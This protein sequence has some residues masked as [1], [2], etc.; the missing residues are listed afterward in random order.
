MN[1]TAAKAMSSEQR[2]TVTV[3]EMKRKSL[4]YL[5][6]DA[7]K[8]SIIKYLSKLAIYNILGWTREIFFV[9]KRKF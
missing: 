3:T 4:G 5:K 8:S 9:R 1:R 7:K 6:L 2:C